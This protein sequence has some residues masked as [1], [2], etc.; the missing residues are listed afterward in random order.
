MNNWSWIYV[1][2]TVLYFSWKADQVLKHLAKIEE[3]LVDL[4]TLLGQ[5]FARMKQDP[6]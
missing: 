6:N 1:L 2:L 5:S 4:H 3:R